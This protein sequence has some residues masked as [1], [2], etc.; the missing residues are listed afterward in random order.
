M[1][2]AFSF[3]DAAHLVSKSNLWEER[4]RAIQAKYEKLNNEVLP[5]VAVDKQ[6]RVGCKGKDKFWYGYKQHVMR[7]GLIN[8]ISITPA[9]V[10][11]TKGLKHVLPSSGVIY[12]DKGYCT[13]DAHQE[14][15]ASECHLAAI[16]KNNMKGKNRDQ[17]RWYSRVRSPHERAFSQREKRVW[18]IGKS[19]NQF[20]AFMMS[21]MLQ[22]EKVNSCRSTRFSP[23]VGAV[24]P[25]A[26]RLAVLNTKAQ[27]KA[28][29]LC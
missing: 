29:I 5:K 7:L 19:K 8:K 14:A 20:S 11:D 1:S 17:D 10:T 28:L 4:D 21:N 12:A 2:E 15:K 13:K 26:A 16:K 6:A 24:R 18:Y 3:V 27:S 9:K 25:I 23:S 22:P